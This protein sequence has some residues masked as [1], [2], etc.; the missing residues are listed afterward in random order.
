V[1]QETGNSS[2]TQLKIRTHIP[3]P[4]ILYRLSTHYA[5]PRHAIRDLRVKPLEVRVVKKMK[6]HAA[7][8]DVLE[9]HALL[10]LE[11]ARRV[12]NDLLIVK[13]QLSRGSR[14]TSTL[15]E[16]QRQAVSIMVLPVSTHHQQWQ[17]VQPPHF[18]ETRIG[19]PLQSA[20]KVFWSPAKNGE[21][22]YAQ[23]RFC[24]QSN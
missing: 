17:N 5:Y 20:S 3:H 12:P 8:F 21:G 1:H 16:W 9:R 2:A 11:Q 15:I 4:H 7:L 14:A 10:R 18:E 24:G 6:V 13:E 19:N 22:E 23:P